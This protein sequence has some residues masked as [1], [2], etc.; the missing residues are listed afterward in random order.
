MTEIW[1]DVVGFED[2]YQVSNM[3]RVKSKSR[4]VVMSASHKSAAHLSRRKGR[5]LKPG[6]A[7]NGYFTVA[8]GRGNSRTI[9]SL[10]AE[11][12]IGPCPDGHEVLH[13]D[14][15]R[16]NNC[17]DNLRYGTRRENIMDAVR[18]GSWMTDER[19]QALDKG[20]Q[21]RWGDRW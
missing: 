2:A 11:A 6:K 8:L 3:G 13:I 20:R 21:T 15:T 9:H 10:V 1:R 14:G 17:A 4:V 7:S 5:M 12:F 19:R 18:H 16:T